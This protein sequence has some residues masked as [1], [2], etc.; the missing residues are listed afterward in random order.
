MIMRE[1][2]VVLAIL[3]ISVSLLI[4]V[5]YPLFM[6]LQTSLTSNGHIGLNVFRELLSKSYNRRPLVNSV[7]LG[8]I[9]ALLGT[10]IGFIFAYATVR[11]NIPFKGFFKVVATFPMISPPLIM[12][13]ATILLLGNN[14]VITRQLLHGLVDFKIYGLNGLVLVETLAYF[15][16]AYLVLSGILQAIDPSLE[17]A[18]L[19]LGASRWQV[20][21]TITLPLATPG[22]ASALLLIFIESLA[23][24]GN[25]IILSGNYEVLAV[26]AYLRITGLYDL[27]GGA[28]LAVILL[29]PSL[30]AFFLQKYWVSRKSYV[31]VTGKPSARGAR[32]EGPWVRRGVFALCLGLT[33]IILVFYGTVL[34]GSFVT[35]WGAN[36]KL[37][38]SN[39]RH[40][41]VVG[42]EFIKDTLFLSTIA[43]PITGILGMIIAF[44]VVRK[45][46]F[47]RGALELAS[48]LTFAVPGTVVGIGYILAFNQPPLMLTGTAAIII[49]LFIFRN[50]P[51][52]IQAGIAALQQI[53]P[54]IEEASRDLGGDTST[55]FRRIT[56]PLI[57]PAFFSGLVFS[58]VRCVTAIS[59]IIFVVSGRW[60]LITVA[61]LGAIENSDLA[62]AAAFCVVIIVMVLAAIGIINLLVYQPWRNGWGGRFIK[63]DNTLGGQKG[64]DAT[65]SS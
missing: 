18:A 21:R 55:T 7:R 33:A 41:F 22:I 38:L 2:L 8:A 19:D 1:P 63:A 31:T 23:D 26:Q 53:D 54:S 37:T 30:A 17:D 34:I 39:Y 32:D 44:L 27:P 13:L 40:V 57:A 14:G 50:M 52:G 4:F 24:F 5:I 46:F 61:V 64:W 3:A 51:T 12:S 62:Q 43:T 9:V 6:V 11:V 15:P 48:M 58:F 25:P 65:V 35:L 16:T 59:A 56:L 36:Y 49:L 29:V 20:F 10:V 47:G 45:R 42:W 28:A 60:N